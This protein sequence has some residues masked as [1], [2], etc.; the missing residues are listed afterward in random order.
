MKK[1]VVI[2]S[3]LVITL[4]AL[5]GY[6]WAQFYDGRLHIV[7]CDVGQGSATLIKTPNN[8]YILDDAGPDQKV[9]DCLSRHMPFWE[10]RIAL[11]LLT[12][13]HAD[14]YFGMFELL[15]RYRVDAFA[16]E[17]YENDETSFR[18]LI[19][20]LSDKEVSQQ[21]VLAGDS[22]EVGGVA[23][24]VVG[25]S[26]QYLSQFDLDSS[27]GENAVSVMVQV[28]YGDFSVLLPGDT[29]VS[30]LESALPNLSDDLT[31]FATAH[32]GSRTSL[33]EEILTALSPEVAIISAGEENKY[34]HPHPE[35]INLLKQHQIPYFQTKE[36]DIEF[37][38]DGKNWWK[39]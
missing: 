12:H 16:T 27:E 25:P 26:E 30:G 24:S 10:R 20:M 2:I 39:K 31:I 17:A 7:F 21:R 34:G 13:P 35:V 22:W 5:I 37:V 33:D 9:L 1:F 14:H 11:L 28:S 36:G 23:I 32:H 18:E 4:L 38:S 8:Q 19:A 15:S 6:Q 29:Q 3:C